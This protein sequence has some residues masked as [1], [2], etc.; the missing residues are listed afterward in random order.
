MD[1]DFDVSQ[2]NFRDTARGLLRDSFPASRLREVWNQGHDYDHRLWKELSKLGVSGV[3]IDDRFGGF[4]GDVVDL[5]L[6]LEEFGAATVPEPVVETA[7]IA[8]MVI[9]ALGDDAVKKRWLPGLAAGDLVAAVAT[10]TTGVIVADGLSADLLV[11]CVDRQVHLVGPD[12]VT[13]RRVQSADPSRRLAECDISVD[14]TTLLSD[15]ERAV[16]LVERIGAVGTAS[17]LVGL[18]QHLIEVTRDYLLTRHQFGR[19]IGEFQALKHRLADVAVQTEAA[20]SLTWNA[21]YRLRSDEGDELAAMV[22]KAA[23]SHA[24]YLAGAA[25]LQLHGGIGFTWEH[26]LHLWLQR[27]KAW[28]AAFGSTEQH[29]ISVGAAILGVAV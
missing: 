18:S 13:G 1:F 11:V 26:D 12:R 4:G 21:G 3:L 10:G 29:R 8:P 20:R 14:D 2:R 16:P 22:A 9:G 23:A 24:G 15:D 19:P 7:L 28:E 25:A 27:G 17:L 6:V 5:L